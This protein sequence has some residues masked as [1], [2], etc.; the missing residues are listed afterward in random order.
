MI[1]ILKKANR[2]D[3]FQGKD[4]QY[5]TFA[6]PGGSQVKVS[7]KDVSLN[8]IPDLEPISVEMEVRGRTGQYGQQLEIVSISCKRFVEKNTQGA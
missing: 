8:E 1:V 3:F 6:E 2:I 5:M 7:S 4:K